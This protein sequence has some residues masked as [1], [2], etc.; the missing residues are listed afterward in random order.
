[1]GELIYRCDITPRPEHGI[2][3]WTDD[4]IK[5]AITQAISRDGR[6]FLPVMP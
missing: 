2:G 5:R 4:E 1:M 3:A 6:Q